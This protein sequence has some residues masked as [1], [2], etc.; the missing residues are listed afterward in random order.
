M[1]QCPR[2]ERGREGPNAP[3]AGGLRVGAGLLAQQGEPFSLQWGLGESQ[4]RPA[5]G[6][7]FGEH[8]FLPV[9]FPMAFYL[10]TSSLEM[11]Y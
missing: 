6:L 8:M 7:T 1:Y 9:S 10:A 5:F 4:H 2:N 11:F 3:N